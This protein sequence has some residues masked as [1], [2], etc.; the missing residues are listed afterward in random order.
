[1][2]SSTF[3]GGRTEHGH[4]TLVGKRLEKQSLERTRRYRDEK[5]EYDKT[6]QTR[7]KH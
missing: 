3:G 4:R 1:M 6:K 2:A 5:D 7:I